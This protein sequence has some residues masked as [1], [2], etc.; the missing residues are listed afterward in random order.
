MIVRS[1]YL[2]AFPIRQVYRNG[3]I[4]WNSG[5]PIVILADV[6]ISTYGKATLGVPVLFGLNGE[7]ESNVNATS[8]C[9]IFVFFEVAGASENYSHGISNVNLLEIIDAYADVSNKSYGKALTTLFDIIS[10]KAAVK[11][12]TEAG[13][14]TTLFAFKSM[15]SAEEVKS[16]TEAVAHDPAFLHLDPD[17][18]L[19]KTYATALGYSFWFVSATSQTES[20]TEVLAEAHTPASLPME[21]EDI[22]LIT[23]ANA[24]ANSIP[25]FS[26]SGFSIADT[27]G[28]AEVRKLPSESIAAIAKVISEALGNGIPLPA[29]SG[30]GKNEITNEGK[31]ALVLLYLPALQDNVLKIPSAYGASV[32]DGVLEVI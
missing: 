5:E 25:F 12:T 30:N 28:S 3:N 14:I 8:A 9:H 6:K 17:K 20:N 26:I 22:Y 29:I 4:I 24:I 18:V 16:Y 23:Y 21:A 15:D 32:V 31:G 13:A 2:G 10:T 27:F 11:E 1:L 19:I 7:G